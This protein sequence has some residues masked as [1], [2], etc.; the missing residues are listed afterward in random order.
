MRSPPSSGPGTLPA[1]AAGGPQPD[2]VAKFAIGARRGRDA[3][4][5]WRVRTVTYLNR[6]R[7]K[8]AEV[9]NPS[10]KPPSKVSR[11]VPIVGP[12]PAGV[13]CVY[14]QNLGPP[15]TAYVRKGG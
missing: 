13:S 7:R 12:G 11:R 4:C 2:M 8:Y 5:V 10:W 6:A 14:H 1:Y 3:C 9:A 15:L